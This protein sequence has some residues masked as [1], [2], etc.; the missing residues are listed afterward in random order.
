[1]KKRL[2]AMLASAVTAMS[3]I[4]MSVSAIGATKTPDELSLAIE[5]FTEADTQQYEFAAKLAED[6]HIDTLYVSNNKDGFLAVKSENIA[7]A[8]DIVYA[9]RSFTWYFT[10]YAPKYETA[11]RSYLEDNGIDAYVSYDIL[12]EYL[13]DAEYGEVFYV[14]P[15]DDISVTEQL[16]L[17]E[18]IYKATGAVPS[19]QMQADAVPVDITILSDN[20][21]GDA[22]CDGKAD[23]A[24][25]V[26][27]QQFLSNPEKYPI[28]KQGYLNADIVGNDGVTSL[29]ALEIQKLEAGSANG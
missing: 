15:N 12:D 5:G 21:A 20:V 10:A 4:P 7:A 25:A 2:I 13:Q 3:C 1:M 29:D 23:I 27:I 22:N 17:A 11:V 18:M 9:N 19:V 16:E 14:Y 24:D 28:S 8:K 26:L 6:I